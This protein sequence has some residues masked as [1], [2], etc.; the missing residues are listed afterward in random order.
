MKLV[1]AFASLLLA[2]TS[3]SSS[4][5]SGPS[6]ACD[7]YTQDPLKGPNG[8]HCDSNGDCASPTCRCADG[9]KSSSQALCFN[10]TCD[11]KTAC[12]RFCATHGGGASCDAGTD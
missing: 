3:S 11:G 12:T 8:A 7:P 4:T 9:A 2:C 1:L 10:L 6:G 5:P